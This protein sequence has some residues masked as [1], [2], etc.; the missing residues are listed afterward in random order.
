MKNLFFVRAYVPVQTTSILQQGTQQN[1]PRLY[2]SSVANSTEYSLLHTSGSE[3]VDSALCLA[4]Q[5]RASR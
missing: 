4:L 3:V 1:V 5:Q 2:I